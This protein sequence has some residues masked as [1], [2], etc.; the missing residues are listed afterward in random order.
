[1]LRTATRTTVVMTFGFTWSATVLHPTAPTGVVYQVT[2]RYTK[3]QVYDSAPNV[4]K[5]IRNDVLPS[6]LNIHSILNIPN[7][8]GVPN[9]KT[10]KR[11]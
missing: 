5:L 6:V 2:N 3:R 8:T 10:A 11:T 7:A 9:V 4:P 1:M